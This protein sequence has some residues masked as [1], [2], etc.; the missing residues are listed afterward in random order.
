MLDSVGY[1]ELAHECNVLVV[2]VMSVVRYYQEQA[3]H[4]EDHKDRSPGTLRY[5]FACPAFSLPPPTHTVHL[6]ILEVLLEPREL[7]INAL[8]VEG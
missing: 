8:H 5:K 7:D 3:K 2:D 6:K 4:T 1:V